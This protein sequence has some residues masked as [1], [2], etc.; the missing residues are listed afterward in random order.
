MPSPLLV[1]NFANYRNAEE[2]YKLSEFIV[3]PVIQKPK[4]PEFALMVFWINLLG[5]PVHLHRA[6]V[7][8]YK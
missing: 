7:M 6:Y 5:I 4:L 1:S 2:I 8:N 3:P